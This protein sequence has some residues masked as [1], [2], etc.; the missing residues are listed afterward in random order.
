MPDPFF[1]HRC[2]PAIR[3]P[4]AQHDRDICI[5][6]RGFDTFDAD[7]PSQSRQSEQEQPAQN[8]RADKDAAAQRHRIP[9]RS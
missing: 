7:P 5:A 1:E 4:G 6:R 2:R 9:N 8:A 3:H